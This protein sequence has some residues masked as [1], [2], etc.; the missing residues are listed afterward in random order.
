MNT[1]LVTDKWQYN[2]TTLI[3]NIYIS[4]CALGTYLI[5]NINI[6]ENYVFL[7]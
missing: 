1:V 2:I 6:K 5:M 4:G 3:I 7:L